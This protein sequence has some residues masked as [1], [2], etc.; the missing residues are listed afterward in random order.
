MPKK[1]PHLQTKL[2]NADPQVKMYISELTKENA[3][4]QKQIMKCEVKKVSLNNRINA[5]EKEMKDN[6][7]K[8]ELIVDL[9]GDDKLLP[10]PELEARLIKKLTEFGYRIEKIAS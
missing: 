6:R 5:L 4:L 7:G 8:F 2:Q 3:L 9:S 1:A 10:R